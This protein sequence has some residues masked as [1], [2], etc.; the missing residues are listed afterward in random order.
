M[1]FEE[2]VIS[3]GNDFLSTQQVLQLEFESRNLPPIEL[4][5][6][7]G[8]PEVWPEFTENF[9]SRVNRMASFDNNLK[10]GRLLSVFDR[11]AKRSIQSIGSS[12]ILCHRTKSIET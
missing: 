3:K 6:F 8:N 2:T 1:E 10:M 7:D 9:Y 11:D 12:G 4:K 5:R